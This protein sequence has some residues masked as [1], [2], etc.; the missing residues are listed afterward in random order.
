[1][2]IFF[3]AA[4]GNVVQKPR[5]VA[6]DICNVIPTVKTSSHF[7]GFAVEFDEEHEDPSLALRN[8]KTS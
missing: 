3:E 2:F 6:S 4:S 7:S 8:S 1:M 5:G